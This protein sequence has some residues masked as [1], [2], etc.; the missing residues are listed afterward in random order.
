V[1]LKRTT[2]WTELL[3]AGEP[4]WTGLLI[5][6][7]VPPHIVMRLGMPA[8]SSAPKT[9]SP[10]V[11]YGSAGNGKV[12]ALGS[13]GHIEEIAPPLGEQIEPAPCVAFHVA[14]KSYALWPLAVKS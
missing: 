7:I 8:Y 3:P 4:E 12:E 11:T 6:L 13:A 2:S 10:S 9:D 1:A 5:E 14:R